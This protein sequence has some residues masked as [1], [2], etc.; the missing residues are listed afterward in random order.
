MSGDNLEG[1][2]VINHDDTKRFKIFRMSSKDGLPGSTPTNFTVNMAN[3]DVRFEK[4]TE[5]HVKAVSFMNGFM[6]IGAHNNVFFFTSTIYAPVP[7]TVSVP[8]GQYST[9]QLMAALQTAINAILVPLSASVTITQDPFTQ[10]I[11]FLFVNDSVFMYP[12]SPMAKYLG[13]LTANQ[14][15]TSNYTCDTIPNLGGERIIY[16]HSPQIA[17]NLTYISDLSQT[18]D[19]N[20]FASVAVT[21]P[22]GAYQDYYGYDAD[23]VVYGRTGFNLRNKIQ[24][25]LRGAQGREL[26]LP[27]N[28]ETVVVLKVFYGV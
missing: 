9:S 14:F 26:T 25:I 13:I 1:L 24:I 16:V 2:L 3:T 7:L 15:I 23:R 22:Y 20:G 6:N 21:V 11:N 17:P 5:F 19:V 18:A 27:G 8:I 4:V 10:K 28:A 12:T